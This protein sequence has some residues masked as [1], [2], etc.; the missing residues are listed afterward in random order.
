MIGYLVSVLLLTV[1]TAL[2]LA[3]MR[4][5]WTR[6]QVSWRL[7]FQ[8][9]EL[10]FV[11]AAWLLAATALAALDGNLATPMGATALVL[12]VLTLAGLTVIAGRGLRAGR[13]V[14]DALAEGLGAGWRTELPADLA[15]R[16]PPHLPWLRI[17]FSPLAMR[18]RDVLH[19]RN[20]AYGP[21][22]RENLLDVY[23]PRR[24]ATHGACLVYFHG[25]G[26][27]GGN[28]NREARALL[29]R[30]ASEGW[31][32]VSANYRRGR[33]R[34]W[35]DQL[36]DAHRAIAW[37]RAAAADNGHAAP[38]VFV[39]GSSAGAHLAAM[40]ALTPPAGTGP[41]DARLAGAICLY[42]FYGA[43]GWI[44]REPSA[45]SAPID[46][47][48]ATAVPFFIAHGALDSF[49]AAAEARHFVAR[50]RLVSR[51]P[52]VY[53]ELPGGQHTFDLYHSMRFE[54]VV[55]GVESATA[56]LRSVHAHR[57]A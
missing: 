49:V 50:L 14:S 52:V 48:D 26:Y 18:R 24:S 45:P 34:R 53:A 19:E 4:G 35:P 15:D 2:A 29:Y 37:T 46:L 25:G 20:L 28:K 42:G 39:A 38:A 56:W 44:D 10:P 57:R 30:L 1:P 51:Q 32:C 43:P 5:S 17:V 54:A 21:A 12:A 22:G 8:V 3:P 47:V 31:L 36:I 9:N 11:A 23:R 16:L 33:G 13:A 27:R 7:G 55:D 6:G 41:A 40:A